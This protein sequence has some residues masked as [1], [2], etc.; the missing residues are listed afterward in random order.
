VVIVVIGICSFIVVIA[1]GIR[2]FLDIADMIAILKHSYL[3]YF[4]HQIDNFNYHCFSSIV[5]SSLVLDPVRFVQVSKV[6][7]S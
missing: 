7:A 3:P 2:Y 1:A 6:I 5:S 4:L